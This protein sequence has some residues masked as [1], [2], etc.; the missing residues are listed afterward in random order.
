MIRVTMILACLALIASAAFAFVRAEASGRSPASPQVHASSPS[1]HA[2]A[3]ASDRNSPSPLVADPQGVTL[4]S[5]GLL[6]LGAGM[7]RHHA[8]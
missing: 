6:A 1:P 3:P 8:P 7:R 2:T 4:A 5:L